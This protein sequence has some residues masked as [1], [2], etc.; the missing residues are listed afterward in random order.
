VIDLTAAAFRKETV[1]TINFHRFYTY[2]EL[3]VSNTA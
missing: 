2:G 3:S 1:K